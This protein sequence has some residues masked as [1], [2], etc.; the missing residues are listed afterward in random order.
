MTRQ[1]QSGK[2]TVYYDL[3]D[4]CKEGGCPI[5]TLALD[6]VTRYLDSIIYES[7]NDPQTRQAL[8]QA[9][10]YCNDHSWRLT[11]MRASFSTA[12]LYRDVLR[13][14]GE[15]MDEQADQGR[16]DLFGDGQPEG[17][18]LDR[19]AA[20]TGGGAPSERGHSVADPH[21]AC[22]ACQVRDRY[23]LI[24]LGALLEHVGEGEMA[25]ALR[26]A[27]GL[28]LVHLDRVAAVTH[29][30]AA[31]G[32]LRDVQRAC[33]S[34]LGG[35]LSEFIRKHDYRFTDEGMGAEGNAWLR[36]VA[37]V[38]GKRGIR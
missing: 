9:R 7:V 21:L 3:L 1:A 30:G 27:G 18:L 23:E 28:C 4:A 32:R 10:G 13:Q 15:D 31:I 20:L 17:G 29:D 37:M 14:A 19:L 34:A 6:M 38:A 5:C 33:M 16:L 8:V 25:G 24:V 2:Q 26:G 35:E 36:A 12:L 22:P 11:E